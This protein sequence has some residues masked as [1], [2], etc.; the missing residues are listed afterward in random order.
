MLNFAY[1]T[2]NWG[3]TTDL[4]KAFAEIRETGWHAVELFGHSLDWMGTPRRLKSLLDKEGLKAATIFASVDL[5][6][7]ERQINLHKNKLDYAAEIGATAYGLVG[8]GRPR[9]RPPTAEEIADLAHL[10][11]EVAAYGD[12][13]GVVTA[14]HPHTRCT[15]QYQHEIDQLVSQTKH[16]Q[17]CLDV[18]HIALVSEDPLAHLRKYKDRLGY[19]HLKDW[20]NGDFVELGLGTIGIDFDACLKEL[21][22]QNFAGWVVLEQS[23]SEVSAAHSAKLNADYLA[24]LGYTI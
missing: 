8:A 3:D 1:S 14:Y 13:V 2:I 15:I 10:C 11:D 22:N 9:A 18:S 19:V 5:P 21:Q 17:L 4:A 23:L 16:L 20:G 6:A 12:S 24:K 7:S